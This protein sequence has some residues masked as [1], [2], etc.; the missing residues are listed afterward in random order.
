[1]GGN[2]FFNVIGTATYKYNDKGFY[3]ITD[4]FALLKIG[5]AVSESKSQGNTIGYH[6]KLYV[7]CDNH[8]GNGLSGS[9]PYIIMEG[10]A[11]ITGTDN[12]DI[13]IEKSGCSPGYN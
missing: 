4:S 10:D 13:V 1:M 12:A 6:G 3:G 11:Q 2:S 7:A 5:K 9:V 8:F